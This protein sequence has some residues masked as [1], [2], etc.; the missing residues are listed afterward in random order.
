M[1]Q[2]V[3]VQAQVPEREPVCRSLLQAVR[4]QHTCSPLALL[5][6]LLEHLAWLRKWLLSCSRR[7]EVALHAF[8]VRLARLRLRLR[9]AQ[10]L[11]L[12]LLQQRLGREGRHPQC[13]VAHMLCR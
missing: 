7:G 3:Q 5:P 6:R 9:P 11:N 4:V 13:L 12:L 1:Q 10:S 8:L 2:Q